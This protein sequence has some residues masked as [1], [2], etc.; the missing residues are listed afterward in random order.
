MRRAEK[1][2]QGKWADSIPLQRS[3]DAD[4]ELDPQP[5]NQPT[6]RA[7]RFP[8]HHHLSPIVVP[9][10]AAAAPDTTG[11]RARTGTG[12]RRAHPHM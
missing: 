8:S 9:V 3:I 2:K 5:T 10:V 4:D 1:G 12:R 6:N 11:R 7:T